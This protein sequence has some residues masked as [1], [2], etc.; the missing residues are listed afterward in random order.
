MTVLALA[1]ITPARVGRVIDGDKT[2][3]DLLNRLRRNQTP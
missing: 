3:D 1:W 2:K